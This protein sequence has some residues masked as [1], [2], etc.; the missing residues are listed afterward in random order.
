MFDKNIINSK[1]NFTN[2]LNG[3]QAQVNL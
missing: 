2:A 3:E 1:Q